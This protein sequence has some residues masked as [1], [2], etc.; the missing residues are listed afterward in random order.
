MSQ[1]I[2]NIVENKTIEENENKETKNLITVPENN[3]NL[4]ENN[5]IVQEDEKIKE[6]VEIKRPIEDGIYAIESKLNS[7]KYVSVENGSMK[8]GANVQVWGNKYLKYNQFKVTYLNNGYYSIICQNSDKSLDV[9]HA[10]KE[11]GTN[12]AQGNYNGNSA[13]QWIIKEAKDGYYYIM[14]KCNNLY[15]DIYHA[16]IENGTNIQMSNYSRKWCTNV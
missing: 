4:E 1:A 10:G 2:S 8:S 7:S 6:N 9:Y 15:L 12:I 5:L 13:Q 3:I 11:S 14:S 16:N